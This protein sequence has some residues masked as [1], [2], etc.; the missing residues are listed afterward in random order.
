MCCNDK[1]LA[2]AQKAFCREWTCCTSGELI[3]VLSPRVLSFLRIMPLLC[4]KGIGC[5]CNSGMWVSKNIRYLF[6]WPLPMLSLLLLV[7]R[8]N[9][10][11]TL[12]LFSFL[13][14]PSVNLKGEWSWR[15]NAKENKKQL[16]GV[17]GNLATGQRTGPGWWRKSH[18][19]PSRGRI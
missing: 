19:S 8:S 16:Q 2:G 9:S 1:M 15:T 11:K 3:L 7:S 6:L 12:A 5:S 13:M 17:S 4:G 14:E 18:S 10:T